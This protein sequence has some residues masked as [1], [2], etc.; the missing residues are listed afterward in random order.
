MSYRLYAASFLYVVVFRTYFC[1]FAV[2][3]HNRVFRTGHNFPSASGTGS[4]Y[5]WY[6][7][8]CLCTPAY[9]NYRG[10]EPQNVRYAATFQKS[11]WTNYWWCSAAFHHRQCRCIHPVHSAWSCAPVQAEQQIPAFSYSSNRC[12][13]CGGAV[14]VEIISISS[15]DFLKFGVLDQI[16][17]EDCG[18]GFVV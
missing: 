7:C 10:S 4:T 18:I 8:E 15:F 11:F 5:W 3:S 14:L 6:R 13:Y 12:N 1:V 16:S 17:S 2:Y 9:S